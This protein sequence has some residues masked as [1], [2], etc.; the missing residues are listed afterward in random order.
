VWEW[1]SDFFGDYPGIAQ[2]NSHSSANSTLRVMRGGSWGVDAKYCRSAFRGSGDQFG[3][4]CRLGFR[5]V[6]AM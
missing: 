2:S 5:L 4:Y 3:R 6:F 1:C